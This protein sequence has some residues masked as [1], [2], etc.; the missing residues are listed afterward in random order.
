M[1][2]KHYYAMALD[3]HHRQVDSI[4]SNPAECLWARLVDDEHAGPMIDTLM[5]DRLFTSWGIRTMANTERAYNPFSYHNGSI[6]PFENALIAS[7][8]KKYG[9]VGETQ[10]VLDAML[11]ASLSFEYR[12]W[13]E[14]YAGVSREVGGVLA[15]Q[16][17]ASRP[18]AWSAGAIFSLLQ[19]ILGVAQAPFSKRVDITPALPS[20]MN[21][22]MVTNLCIGGCRL[23]LRLVR[24]GTSVLMDIVDNPDEVDIVVHPAGH[25]HHGEQSDDMPATSG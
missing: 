22:I 11:D 12:R 8:L 23:S 5:S 10:A 7:G 14:V 4:T 15:R 18:Q 16:P 24:D 2:E 1:P 13:P 21:A 3:G 9:Y 17:D 25:N 6:W 19:T 20:C